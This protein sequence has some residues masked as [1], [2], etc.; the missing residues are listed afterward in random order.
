MDFTTLAVFCILI[1]ATIVVIVLISL[2]V[3]KMMNFCGKILLLL[4][5]NINE[6]TNTNTNED[7]DADAN[8][9]AN[10]N[11]KTN[12]TASAIASAIAKALSVKNIEKMEPV[13]V[14]KKSLGDHLYN[15]C[16]YDVKT[17]DISMW[18]PN[19]VTSATKWLNKRIVLDGDLNLFKETQF[20]YDITQTNILCNLLASAIVNN[21]LAAIREIRIQTDSNRLRKYQM[22]KLLLVLGEYGTNS[23]LNEFLDRWIIFDSKSAEAQILVSV[24]C[25]YGNM[26]VLENLKDRGVKL[27][28]LPDTDNYSS[29]VKKFLKRFSKSKSESEYDHDHDHD[30]DHEHEHEHVNV[31]EHDNTE[32]LIKKE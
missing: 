4:C 21:K 27:R 8:A 15:S 26:I 29:A 11:A 12:V 23:M 31:H 20:Q 17:S 5:E 13:P 25:H 3:I 2:G 32:V 22:K 24:A 28:P 10:A 19:V 6:D 9:N 7:E 16:Y 18:P 30:H 1:Y 14:M